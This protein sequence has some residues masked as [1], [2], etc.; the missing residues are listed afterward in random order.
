[1]QL[2]VVLD[3]ITVF[4]ELVSRVETLFCSHC[5]SHPS[6]STA[7]VRLPPCFAQLSAIPC[8]C[9][10]MRVW[11]TLIT[12]ATKTRSS[13]CHIGFPLGMKFLVQ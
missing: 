6:P 3:R 10:G 1:M 12:M 13:L 9:S 8:V 5:S 11:M 7:R 2:G 4:E